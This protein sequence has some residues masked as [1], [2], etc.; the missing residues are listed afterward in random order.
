MAFTVRSGMIVLHSWGRFRAQI[1]DSGCNVGDL[2]KWRRSSSDEGVER[3]DGAT[4]AWGVSLEERREDEWGWFA[5]AVELKAPPQIASAGGAVTQYYWDTDTSTSDRLVGDPLYCTTDGKLSGTI[6]TCSQVVGH[7]IDCD[8]ALVT[9]NQYIIPSHAVITGGA[10]TDLTVGTAAYMG[11]W[12]CASATDI[13]LTKGNINLTAGDITLTKGNLNITEFGIAMTAGDLTLTKGNLV[14]TEK[15][16]KLTKGNI[17]ITD[18]YFK[19][20]RVTNKTATDTLTDNETRYVNC[21][22]AGATVLTLPAAAAGKI[23]TVIH[24]S[25]AQNINIIAGSGDKIRDPEDGG[26]HD[27]LYDKKGVDGVVTLLA[28]NASNWFVTYMNGTWVG[29]DT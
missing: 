18:G 17:I 20:T 14:I 8:R 21:A 19:E 13:T 1:R 5:T 27:Y 24:F 29:A 28:I 12:K 4:T 2:V 3:C 7:I 25:T 23:V 16:S 10:G 15:D 22:P 26:E 6:S 11:T 9:P